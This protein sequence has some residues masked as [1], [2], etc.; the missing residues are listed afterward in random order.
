MAQLAETVR[1]SR[2]ATNGIRLHVAEAG[3][4]DGPLVVLLHGFPEFWFGWRNQIA[5]LAER[6]FHIVAPDQRGYNLSDKP[7]GI[8]AYD[9]DQLAADVLGLADHFRQQTFSV[10]GHDWGAAVAWWLAGRND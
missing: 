7:K 8:G 2:I 5:P 1:F 10:V 6:G 3:P 4:S 9:L